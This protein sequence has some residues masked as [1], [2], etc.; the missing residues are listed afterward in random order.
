[1]VAAQKKWQEFHREFVKSDIG[2]VV[3]RYCYVLLHR[4][5]SF[6]FLTV[7]SEMGYALLISLFSSPFCKPLL[8][9]SFA[10]LYRVLVNLLGRSLG[11]NY[12]FKSLHS[13]F[14]AEASGILH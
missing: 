13:L 14:G 8:L 11:S 7:V 3:D 6:V 1:M 9:L 2:V 5:F 10:L 4:F 12:D